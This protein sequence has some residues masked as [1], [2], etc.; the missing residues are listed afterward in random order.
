MVKLRLFIK[1]HYMFDKFIPLNKKNKFHVYNPTFINSFMFN[2]SNTSGCIN[3]YYSSIENYKTKA[4]TK[5][6]RFTY[7]G[8]QREIIDMKYLKSIFGTNKLKKAMTNAA[9]Y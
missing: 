9:L 3:L 6:F 2:F 1:L 5:D 8:I 7:N 4:I